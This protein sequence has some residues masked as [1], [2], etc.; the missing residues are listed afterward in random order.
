MMRV[1]PCATSGHKCKR[2]FDMYHKNVD[3][4]ITLSEFSNW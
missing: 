1:P 2:K 3:A 4:I